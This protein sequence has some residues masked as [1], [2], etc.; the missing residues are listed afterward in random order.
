MLFWYKTI[1]HILLKTRQL[2]TTSIKKLHIAS[3]VGRN[4]VT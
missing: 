4:S 3:G 1:L 2:F